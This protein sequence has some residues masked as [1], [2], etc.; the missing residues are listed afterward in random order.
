MR[1]GQKYTAKVKIKAEHEV[2]FEFAPG[3]ETEKE[4]T[5]GAEIRKIPVFEI[6]NSI[7]KYTGKTQ[8]FTPSG[9]G[10]YS[11][12]IDIISGQFRQVNVDKYTVIL[13]LRNAS[14]AWSDGSTGNLVLEFE[15]ERAVLDGEWNKDTGRVNFES[16]YTGNYDEVVEYLY[17]YNKEAIDVSELKPGETYEVYVK[18]KDA[19]IGNF[20]FAD[21]FVQSFTFT[22]QGE[23]SGIAWWLWL[24]LALAIILIIVII[25]IIIIVIK[26]R[27]QTEYEYEDVY[28]DGY[29]DDYPDEGEQSEDEEAAADDYSDI[30][31]DAADD[32]SEDITPDTDTPNDEF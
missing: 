22:Y 5:L 17:T 19:A 16:T 20:E 25:I 12:D 29:F 3:F 32:A 1:Q 10:E 30:Y 7:R 9:W 4:F 28:E 24:L 2:N 31:G 18:L 13:R 8:D 14:D 23:A 15:I 26:R 11:S 27:A 21:D 6:L